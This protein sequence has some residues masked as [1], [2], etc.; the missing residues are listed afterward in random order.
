MID[1]H[2]LRIDLPLH[3]RDCRSSVP[4]SFATHTSSRSALTR[5][6][7]PSPPNFSPRGSAFLVLML[8]S[9][10]WLMSCACIVRKICLPAL[11]AHT[12]LSTLPM[13]Q[14]QES[15]SSGPPDESSGKKA[16]RCNE[17]N[18]CIDKEQRMA[19]DQRWVFGHACGIP[20][21]RS[22]QMRDLN[23]GSLCDKQPTCARHLAVK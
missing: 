18:G 12:H 16:C 23:D 6:V 5:Q 20:S 4:G 15:I 11:T 2:Q 8:P 14:V 13:R 3:R 7:P 10:S 21:A 19:T 1:R 9:A 22:R 17:F